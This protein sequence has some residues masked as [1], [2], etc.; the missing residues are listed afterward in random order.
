MPSK[1][2]FDLT[3]DNYSIDELK[4]LV[5]IH[6]ELPFNELQG[7]MEVMFRQT[8]IQ[9]QLS[10]VE[11]E[12]LKY[13]YQ[14]AEAAILNDAQQKE[15][16]RRQSIM[17]ERFR[18]VQPVVKKMNLAVDSRERI[19][20]LSGSSSTQ[21]TF[22]LEEQIHNVIAINLHSLDMPRPPYVIHEALD[23]NYIIIDG[24]RTELDPI[25]SDLDTLDDF[26]S[27]F[28]DNFDGVELLA[29]ATAPA[30][31]NW[32]RILVADETN[33]VMSI[34]LAGILGFQKISFTETENAVSPPNIHGISRYYDV[35]FEDSRTTSMPVF[36]L[37][38]SRSLLARLSRYTL[39]PISQSIMQFNSETDNSWRRREYATP[40]SLSR[41]SIKIYDD[42]RRLVLL[43][44]ND[45][46][47]LFELE[48]LQTPVT[49][50]P[51]HLQ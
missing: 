14:Q 19:T 48:Y 43:P 11:A 44:N 7:A 33:V 8:V 41:F 22:S 2:P 45:V 26:I 16:L 29:R 15:L 21:C 23:N 51:N 3:I 38:R 30:N 40:I 37:P 1:L 50:F 6:K 13:F 31:T 18:D 9:Y 10:Q 35:E 12:L 32:L 25:Y 36:A 17:H 34:N 4:S 28:N 39:D 49:C 20:S 46:N 42:L 5:G 24:E 27:A 47:L